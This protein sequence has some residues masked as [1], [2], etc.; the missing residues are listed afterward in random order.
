[1]KHE[2][3]SLP[4]T[5]AHLEPKAWRHVNRALVAKAIGE[6]AH[7]LLI[8]PIA[9]RKDELWQHYTLAGEQPDTEYRFRAQLL[10]LDHWYI[11]AASIRRLEH[12]R[13]TALD[14]LSLIVDLQ[15]SLG[16]PE[17]L[18]PGYLREVAH[19]LY[20][21]AYKH[22]NPR[23]NAAQL[24]LAEFQEIETSMTGGH[25]IFIANNGR[26][27]FN[28]SDYLAYAP[29]VAAPVR[30]VWLA[31]LRVRADVATVA[32]LDYS[33]LIRQELDA[34]T[35]AA[36]AHTLRERGLDP[37]QYVFL[38]VH[39]WQWQNRICQLFAGDLASGELVYLGLGPDQYFAQQSIRTFF[40]ASQPKKRY[41]K[42]ALSILN[43]G[44]TRGLSAALG[45]SS[46]AV[47]DWVANLV[48]SDAFLKQ[49]FRHRHYERA[50]ALRSSA[51][52]EMLAALWRESPTASLRP[53]QRL[54]TMAALMHVDR[55][56]ASL[57]AALIRASG[58]A[59]AAWLDAYLQRYLTPLMH[60]F[61]AHNLV[62][63]PHGENVLLVLEAHVPV[64]MIIKDIAEDIAVLNPEIELPVAVR[65]L[66][67]TVPEEVMTLSIFTDV[68]DCVFRFLAQIL[69]QH[70]GYPESD[71][72]QRVADNIRSYQ[73]AQPRLAGKFQRYD[74]FAPHFMRNCLNRLQLTN[75]EMMVDLNAAEPVASLQ[76]V[77]SLPNPIAGLGGNEAVAANARRD[78]AA[79]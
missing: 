14:A 56:G 1:M 52:K 26:L 55:D 29:E 38:P 27:G 8:R 39:P 10:A 76:F 22:A 30:L 49:C 21:A 31:A 44:F 74:L 67:L 60:C 28:T 61:Y 17:R 62:F 19:T 20:S 43:M 23:L 77:G 36:F 24:A 66:A 59:V 42:T 4:D 34:E 47:N 46:A 63:T 54:M 40:N 70:G 5:V 13:E 58:L 16:I 3:P 71:F 37:A 79:R 68:F 2:T 69:Y 6:L 41:V 11:D 73:R 51:Y 25:P 53:G 9:G 48:R 57:L 18:L 50:I 45:Q 64:G 75:N 15:T 7:E 33:E 72:W 78:R 12:G 65:R 35:S 32:D